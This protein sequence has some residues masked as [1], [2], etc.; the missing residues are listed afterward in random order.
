MKPILLGLC[1]CLPLAVMAGENRDLL[2]DALYTEE[3]SRNPAAAA[4]KYREI[5]TRYTDQRALAATALFRLAEIRLKEGNGEEAAKLYQRYLREFP[6][7]EAEV[8]TVRER[9]EKAGVKPPV[10]APAVGEDEETKEIHRL[11]DMLV[12]AP[13]NVRGSLIPAIKKGQT[14]VVEFLL[15]KGMDGSSPDAIE[16]AVATGRLDLCKLLLPEGKP[17]AEISRI[18]L[19]SAVL[20]KKRA[21]LEYLIERGC[22]PKSNR[23]LLAFAAGS[24]G[25]SLTRY[26]L[27]HGVRES[28][29]GLWSFSENYDE[30]ILDLLVSYGVTPP[31]KL[32]DE[33]FKKSNP[34]PR[35][36]LIRRFVYP[37]YFK[38]P[39]IWM[40]RRGSNER[41]N[42]LASRKTD[43]AAPSLSQVLLQPDYLPIDEFAGRNLPETLQILRLKKDG[44]IQ[45]IPVSWDAPFP[46]LQW[47]D[48]LEVSS[49]TTRSDG[50]RWK[51]FRLLRK[52][53]EIPIVYENEG[54]SRDLVLKGDVLVYD[55]LRKEVPLLSAGSLA[56]LL[57]SPPGT[58][59]VKLNPKIVVTRNGWGEIPLAYGSAAAWE[60]PLQAGDRLR[61]ERDR[62][63]TPET[64]PSRENQIVVSFPATGDRSTFRS[65]PPP[66]LVQVLT[67][68]YFG[69][70]YRNP[71]LSGYSFPLGEIVEWAASQPAVV[72][73]QP[74]LSK[75]RI[76]RMEQGTE[77]ILKVDLATA[78]ARCTEAASAEEA[79]KGDVELQAGDIVE[80]ESAAGGGKPWNGFS[81]EENRFFHR[82]LSVK[83]QV[84]PEGGEP[85]LVLLDWQP[86]EWIETEAG[87]LPCKPREGTA[88][89]QWPEIAPDHILG[90]FDRLSVERNGRNYEINEGGFFVREGDRVYTQNARRVIRQVNPKGN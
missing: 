28:D 20:N 7:F 36:Q 63:L 48:I 31:R 71:A 22:D 78:I 59:D 42:E 18:A 86:G 17:S 65:A 52:Q 41:F 25:V 23:D 79:R 35:F 13:D 29:E 49:N 53:V 69:N 66:T 33:G 83:L 24:G 26:L 30:K 38:Q 39:K 21:I 82:V 4:E 46:E 9:L 70:W 89:V 81:Q 19:S 27:D 76:R 47:G 58:F 14:R 80:L 40:V 12:T 87:R 5:L 10:D 50:D 2:R 64:A 57:W 74:D 32:I 54:K 1:L 56:K 55:P 3:V 11:R 90:S 34:G 61:I 8:K 51:I 6:D 43:E 85:K 44:G 73:P 77:K 37:E 16:V 68:C 67:Q 75:I 45:E 88:S 62:V 72:L 15:K 60:F 84:F